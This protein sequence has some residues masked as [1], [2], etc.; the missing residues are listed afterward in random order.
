MTSNLPSK[1][2]N[3]PLKETIIEVRFNPT[4]EAVGD[5]LPGVLYSFL[6]SEYPE[7]STLPLAQ[8]PRPLREKNASIRYHPSH[9][10]SGSSAMVQTGDRVITLNVAVYPG[11]QALKEKLKF[12]LEAANKTGFIRE[13]ERFSLKYINLLDFAEPQKQLQLLKLHVDIA[14]RS[15]EEF[16]FKLRYEVPEGPHKTIIQVGT[17]ATV[18]LAEKEFK[19]LIVDVDTVRDKP[20]TAFLDD[21]VPLLEEAHRVCKANFFSILTSDALKAMQPD[22][23]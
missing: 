15:P 16:G 3:S 18:A 1:L 11:W 9:R 23:D 14:G 6:K 7:V 8:V 10:L 12:V 19:G 21:P 2:G 13:V 17:N 5:V 4:F 22:Y 20:G